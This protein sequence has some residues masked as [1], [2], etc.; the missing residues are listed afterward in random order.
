[1]TATSMTSFVDAALHA[2]DVSL[3][4]VFLGHACLLVSR[5]SVFSECKYK[6][7]RLNVTNLAPICAKTAGTERDRQRMRDGFQHAP[8]VRPLRTT[9]NA[10]AIERT[11]HESREQ[12]DE[13]GF[14]R[15]RKPPPSYA[16]CILPEDASGGS[17]PI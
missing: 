15:E 12:H 10:I 14:G 3:L 7:R 9:M 4:A 16:P 8:R 11:G 13:R 2:A 5:V 17:K 1:M 6:V